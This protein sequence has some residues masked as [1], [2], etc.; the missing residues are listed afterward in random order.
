VFAEIGGIVL[1]GKIIVVL[2]FKL[3]IQTDDF[4]NIF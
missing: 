3:L 2:T 4:L 1:R